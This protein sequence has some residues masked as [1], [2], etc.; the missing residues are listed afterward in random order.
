M[1]SMW[2]CRRLQNTLWLAALRG[3]V[4]VYVGWSW[5]RVAL[6]AGWRRSGLRPVFVVAHLLW[7]CGRSAWPTRRPRKGAR[8]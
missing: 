8:P 4:R 6:E 7:L 5:L 3:G 2:R 1:A